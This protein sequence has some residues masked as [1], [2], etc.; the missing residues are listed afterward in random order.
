MWF[1]LF[2]PYIVLINMT[3]L[4]FKYAGHLELHPLYFT[5]Q[6]M[7]FGSLAL[8]VLARPGPLALETIRSVGTWV[9]AVLFLAGNVALFY[10]LQY[11]D[12]ITAGFL[13]TSSILFS[14]VL[15][16]VFLGRYSMNKKK[17]VGIAGIITGLVV[18]I[19]QMPPHLTGPALAIC[20]GAGLITTLSAFTQEL[21]EASNKTKGIISHELRVTGF[22]IGITALVFLV[23]ILLGAMLKTQFG[24]PVPGVFT[25]SPAQMVSRESML[26]ALVYGVF[27]LSSIRFLLFYWIKRIKTETYLVLAAMLPFGAIVADL[28]GDWLGLVPMVGLTPLQLAAGGLIVASALLVQYSGAAHRREKRRAKFRRKQD[29]I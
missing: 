12:I 26:L 14:L 5:M 2:I 7:V 18:L 16:A 8:L 11:V 19:A 24:V 29:P 4:L 10:T 25:P 17:A 27:L 21:H 22:T 6:A 20:L 23:V 15:A 1:K 9:Y 28:V 3:D 13:K